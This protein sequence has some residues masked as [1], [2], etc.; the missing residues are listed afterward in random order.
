MRINL[1]LTLALSSL[2]CARLEQPTGFSQHPSRTTV[3]PDPSPA[4]GDHAV[5]SDQFPPAD[6]VL[7]RADDDAAK[8][9]ATDDAKNDDPKNNDP[10]NNDPKNNA[11]KNDDAKNDG[12]KEDD[13]KSD[14]AA[15]T[16]DPAPAKPAE[17]TTDKPKPETTS[18]KKTADAPATTKAE[19]TTKESTTSSTSSTTTTQPTTTA[20]PT[21]TSSTESTTSTTSATSQ[22]SSTTGSETSTSSSTTSSSTTKTS[23][24][25]ASTS[26]SN[27][28]VKEWNHNGMVAAIAVSSIVGAIFIGTIVWLCTRNK[29]KG[30]F[31]SKPAPLEVLPVG[32]PAGASTYSMVPLAEGNN[33]PTSEAKFDRGSMM[34]ASSSR[35]DLESVAHSSAGRPSTRMV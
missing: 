4:V 7:K 18:D 33:R 16:T 2:A 23:S 19:P 13:S 31:A 11:P 12:A 26:S 6:R 22:T 30:T 35:T 28:N 14:D 20:E 24:A 8:A 34:F 27:F 9:A 10:K 21:T 1:L 29:L 17:P 3:L 32:A 5:L 15:K 25:A